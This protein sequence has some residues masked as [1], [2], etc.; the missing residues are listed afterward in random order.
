MVASDHGE[1]EA[2]FGADDKGAWNLRFGYTEHSPLALAGRIIR[3]LV[4]S[5]RK[6][7]GG[8]TGLL[9]PEGRAWRRDVD[10]TSPPLVYLRC[11]VLL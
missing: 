6:N 10:E 7:E 8:R 4:N 5:T 9:G 3:L 1:N 11:S 2:G